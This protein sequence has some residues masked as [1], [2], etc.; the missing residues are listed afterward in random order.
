M[1]VQR[2]VCGAVVLVSLLA[3]C[4]DDS[5]ERTGAEP[6]TDE[7]ADGTGAELDDGL[8]VPDGARLAGTVFR[9]PGYGLIEPVPPI[10]AVPPTAVAGGDSAPATDAPGPVATQP[11]LEIDPAAEGWSTVLVV[12]GD[13]FA[14][15]DD[16]AAQVRA[17]GPALAGSADACAWWVEQDPDEPRPSDAR[18]ITDTAPPE[19]IDHLRCEAAASDGTLDIGVALR[20]GGVHPGTVEIAV[21]PDEDGQASTYAEAV[22]IGPVD[23]D[24]TPPEPVPADAGP[25]GTGQ[26]A[27]GP[28]STVTTRQPPDSLP[29]PGPDAV[30]AAA[31][32][33]V[34]EPEPG[35]APEPGDRFGGEGNCLATGY[36]RMVLPE[37]A[38]L[39]A[40]VGGPD[41]TSI[42]RVDD[43][44]AAIDALLASGADGPDAESF[45]PG[46]VEEQPLADG[47]T[48]LAVAWSISA[49]GGACDL[50]ASPDGT[51]LLVTMHSD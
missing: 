32:D 9:R 39:V 5:S 43:V 31:H 44:R 22:T 10:T 13:P 25:A 27:T 35:P 50:L 6:G 18:R 48:V 16:L 15:W 49:G 51:H 3:G 45:E 26:P 12:E 21:R 41:G 47:G 8:V 42:L 36:D 7:P 30:P 19:P 29:T 1:A 34:P 28:T 33:L 2:W 23:P 17:I 46:P 38:E 20:H 40:T 11:P 24:P 4:G 37:G 14:V